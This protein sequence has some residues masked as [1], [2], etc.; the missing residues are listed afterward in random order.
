MSSPAAEPAGRR[1]RAIGWAVGL[2]LVLLGAV[3]WIRLGPGRGPSDEA[4]LAALTASEEL[5]LNGTP[6]WK[7][8]ERSLSNLELPD[9]KSRGLFAERVRLVDLESLDGGE[10]AVT[11]G[12]SGIRE[13]AG[14]VSKRAIDVDG[15]SFHMWGPLL[16]AVDYFERVKFFFVDADYLFSG[17]RTWKTLVGFTALA[18][19]KDGRMLGLHGRQD[20]LWEKVAE[21]GKWLE[22]WRIREWKLTELHVLET[23][24]LPFEDVLDAAVPD[25]GARE[26]ARTSIHENLVAEFLLDYQ[27]P[28]EQRTFRM[29]HKYFRGPAQD[30]HPGLAVCDLDADGYDDFYVVE[31]WG[32]NLFFRNRG[33]GT[34]E[35]IAGRLGIDVEGHSSSALFADYDNDGDD[36]LF[37]GRTLA[38]SQYFENRDGRFVDRSDDLGVSLPYLVSSLSAADYDG[39]GL[40][41]VYFAT[42]ASDMMRVDQKAMTGPDSYLAIA[43]GRSKPVLLQEYLSESDARQLHFLLTTP[44]HEYHVFRNSYGPPN[45]LLKNLGGGRFEESKTAPELRAFRHTYA[46]TWADY[47]D[48]GDPDIYLANDFAPNNMFR[49][50]GGGRFTDVTKE[51]GTADIGFGMGVTWGDYDG[52]QRQDLYVSNMFSKAGRRITAKV[53]NLNPIFAAMAGG[54]S[55]FHN[56]GNRFRKV[57]GM[58]PS[59]IMVEYGDWAWGAQFADFDNDGWLDIYDPAGHYTPPKRIEAQVDI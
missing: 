36:D 45:L 3:V 18:R 16:D 51:T 44:E 59:K 35:E 21:E 50:E 20:V 30:H 52:D 56:E 27:K 23:D 24:R 34:F 19:A 28:P 33:D 8:L 22:P 55:L 42:Y 49:N 4:K 31:R 43:T 40:L 54:N 6:E 32:K 53:P 26:R 1:G 41:D 9:F 12:Q 38:R 57:S 13:R 5:L 10:P 46:A 48:D 14:A 2:G 58:D 47:D 7:R 29:P 37:L 25:P 17:Q 15:A 11:A 39:D